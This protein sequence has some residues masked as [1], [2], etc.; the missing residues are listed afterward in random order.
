MDAKTF[1]LKFNPIQASTL[2]SLLNRTAFLLSVPSKSSYSRLIVYDSVASEKYSIISSCSI[3]TYNYLKL[4]LTINSLTT[5][6]KEKSHLYAN[7][8]NLQKSVKIINTR[9]PYPMFFLDSFV[10]IIKDI[11]SKG[12]ILMLNNSK[13]K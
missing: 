2:D 4:F 5:W 10:M 7:L 13:Q 8:L 6:S 11:Y 9:E 12:M 3:S 1:P